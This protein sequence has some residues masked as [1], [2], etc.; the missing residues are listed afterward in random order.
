MGGCETDLRPDDFFTT[1]HISP[2]RS[3][4][5]CVPSALWISHAYSLSAICT[6]PRVPLIFPSAIVL[7]C[8]APAPILCSV[9]AIEQ[10]GR[11]GSDYALRFRD[12]EAAP[13]PQESMSAHT[14]RMCHRLLISGG[15]DR[16]K[17]RV[18]SSSSHVRS[19]SGARWCLTSSFEVQDVNI[20]RGRTKHRLSGPLVYPDASLCEHDI[21]SSK[22]RL[23]A[24]YP[25]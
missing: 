3:S 20:I 2:H 23:G 17:D 1:S 9:R 11:P 12:R 7:P 5:W 15:P 4:P 6:M 10:T 25:R 13:R 8:A 19:T 16:R 18:L 14:T 21:S 22:A 24:Q